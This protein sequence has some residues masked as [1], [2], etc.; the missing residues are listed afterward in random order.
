AISRAKDELVGVEG[1]RALAK[2]MLDQAKNEDS[3]E[4]AQKC[5]EI[6]EI[7]RHYEEAKRQHRAVD[8][9]DLI[10]RPALLLESNAALRAAALLRHRHVMVDE[11]QDVNR[12]SVRLVK[13][14]AGDGKRLWVVG[15]ARQ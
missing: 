15:D 4:A 7:Y 10:M 13:V 2:A 3:I 11:Y 14:L 5:M 1:Y 6:A 8:F 9:G 12:A